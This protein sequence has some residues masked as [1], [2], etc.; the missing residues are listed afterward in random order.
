MVQLQKILFTFY[1]FNKD[2]EKNAIEKVLKLVK[3]GRIKESRINRSV[4]RIISIKE[5]Y[6]IK[7][8]MPEEKKNWDWVFFF[9]K[10]TQSQF[11]NF[12]FFQFFCKHFIKHLRICLTFSFF[13]SLTN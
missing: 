6:N 8:D 12:L 4:K 7:D 5:K 13:H 9:E 2:E 3:S 10:N 1:L 11:F